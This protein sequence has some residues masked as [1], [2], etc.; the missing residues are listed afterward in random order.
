MGLQLSGKVNGTD[1]MLRHKSQGWKKVFLEC[2]TLGYLSGTVRE[3][4]SSHY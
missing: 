4:S 3:S 2:D 1:Y